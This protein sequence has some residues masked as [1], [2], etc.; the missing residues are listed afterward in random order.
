MK[1]IKADIRKNL[2]AERFYKDGRDGASVGSKETSK[3]PFMKKPVLTQK[4]VTN[5]ALSLIALRGLIYGKSKQDILS[6][7]REMC[8]RDEEI[9]ETAYLKGAKD[10]KSLAM[11]SYTQI[12]L[13]HKTRY[14]QLASIAQAHGLHKEQIDIAARQDKLFHSPVKEQGKGKDAEVKLLVEVS[15]YDTDKLS[16]G[17][18]KY[19]IE[20][21]DKCGGEE[22]DY[23]RI[24]FV[25]NILRQFHIEVQ[26]VLYRKSYYHCYRWLFSISQKNAFIDNWHIK[27]LCDKLQNITAR[28]VQ[29]KRKEKN[30]IVNLPPRGSKTLI[31]STFY[32]IWAWIQNKDLQFVVTSYGEEIVKQKSIDTMNI[33]RSDNFLELFPDMTLSQH[34]GSQTAFSIEGSHGQRLGQTM[35]G[36]VTGFGG[37]VVVIDDPL[38]ASDSLS[39]V[40]R[41]HINRVFDTTITTRTVGLDVTVFVIIMQRLHENDLTGHI[42]AKEGYEQEWEFI[43]V[44]AIAES[45]DDVSPKELYKNFKDGLF[46][47]EYIRRERLEQ[48]QRSMGVAYYGQYLQVPIPNKGI[49]IHNEWILYEQREEIQ[50]ATAGLAVHFIIDLSL[51]K[52]DPT[53]CIAYYFTKNG[54]F[55]VID[56]WWE[57]LSLDKVLEK[58]Q[59]Y[60]APREKEE[61][62]LMRIDGRSIVYIECDNVGQSFMQFMDARKDTIKFRYEPI[63]IPANRDSKEQRLTSAS[64]AFSSSKVYFLKN[65][66]WQA[67]MVHQLTGFPNTKHD[68]LSDCIAWMVLIHK[69]E[70]IIFAPDLL[71]ASND[72][73]PSPPS[74]APLNPIQIEDPYN[75]GFND[76]WRG[77]DQEQ[78]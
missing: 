3:I 38:S 60:T 57:K 59:V 26:R 61:A 5:K 32:V 75:E 22:I 4:H 78:V 1:S 52:G 67:E 10:Y 6:K 43:K 53:G 8:E 48:L 16:E 65:T 9:Y 11:S 77:G 41:E 62:P 71:N 24:I 28:I 20:F 47:K 64:I 46:W 18:R 49:I 40:R 19:L 33:L 14:K 23:K 31:F 54:V 36:G 68:E 12:M 51:G 50:K 25:P 37:H 56:A 29:E 39:K 73:S 45:E 7:M 42:L 34:R 76:P 21:M 72:P 74:A 55:Y 15:I 58:L 27:L 44:P 17:E 35:K 13:Q 63:D 30:L 66:V 69:H 2:F 70:Q